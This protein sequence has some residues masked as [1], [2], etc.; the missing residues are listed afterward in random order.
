MCGVYM[1]N[2]MFMFREEI[3]K[4]STV[5]TAEERAFPGGPVVEICLPVLGVQVQLL[6]GELGPHMLWGQKAKTYNRSNVVT[7]S[8]KTLK[9]NPLQKNLSRKKLQKE[10]YREVCEPAA[11]I[12]DEHKEGFPSGRV[13]IKT[14]EW[15]WANEVTMKNDQRE[16]RP[17]WQTEESTKRPWGRVETG[18]R[19]TENPRIRNEWYD[20]EATSQAYFY[21]EALKKRSNTGVFAFFKDHSSYKVW[22]TS[23]GGQENIPKGCTL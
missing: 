17:P 22:Q 7:N 12:L 1:M 21:S 19:A 11:G 14:E 9:N 2:F 16:G 10:N 6:V 20:L 8:I 23:A 18:R 15:M 5:K 3:S 13:L 4:Y